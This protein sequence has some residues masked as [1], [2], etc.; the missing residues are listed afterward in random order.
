MG[1]GSGRRPTQLGGCAFPKSPLRP[2]PA[3][4]RGALALGLCPRFPGSDAVFLL[5]GRW[6]ALWP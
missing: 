1:R 6:E 2:P 3:R 4:F 5:S